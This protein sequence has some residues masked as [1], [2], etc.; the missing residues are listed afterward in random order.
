MTLIVNKLDSK[1]N[2]VGASILSYLLL[3]KCIIAAI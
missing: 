1:L 3:H 2:I